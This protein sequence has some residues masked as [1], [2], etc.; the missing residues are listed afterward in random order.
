MPWSTREVAD[1][2]GTT[3]NA[4][5]HYHRE[6]LLDE[7]RRTSNGYKQYEVR[8]L[9]R[10]LQIRR[11]RDLGVSLDRIDQLSS[12]EASPREALEAIL[13]D[14]TAGIDRL[15]R[16]R[17]GVIAIL[18]GSSITGVPEGFEDVAEK[19]SQPE[20]S[21]TLI[22]S[23]LF[24]DEAMADVRKMIM[25]E[26]R[27][28]AAEF[29]DLPPDAE[30]SVKAPI[31][32]LYAATIADSIRRYPWLI[33][34]DERLTVGVESARHAFLDASAELYNPAQLDVLVRASRVAMARIG[35][36]APSA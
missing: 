16:A 26:P 14:L 22:Y 34:P 2:A 3:T 11:L 25:D 9:V 33:T 30:E 27:E 13:A 8:H 29:L 36:G 23:Q 12:S 31:I 21:L 32:E 24:N 6:G 20:R 28:G 4:V 15:L 18:E 1:L 10:L 7:P 5:R 35:E 19:L 17:A